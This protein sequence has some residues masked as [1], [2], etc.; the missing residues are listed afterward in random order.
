[1]KNTPDMIHGSIPKGILCFSLPLIA[2]NLLQVFYSAADTMIVSLSSEPDAVGAVGT[3]TPMITLVVNLFISC[4]I[5]AKVAAA[6]RLGAGDN[7]GTHRTV[8]TAVTLSIFLGILCCAAGQL[9]SAPA[10]RLMG[11]NGRLLE[12]SV[13]YT[14]I[15]FLGTPFVAVTNFAMAVFHARGDSKTPLAVLGCTGLLNVLLNMLLV[16]A[17]GLDV[18]GIAAAT[19]AANAVSAALLLW[20]LTKAD[21][22]VR[23]RL[24]RLGI[25]RAPLREILRIG[26]PAVAQNVLFNVSHILLQSSVV[27]VNNIVSSEGSAFQPVVKGNAVSVTFEEFGHTAVSSSAQAAISYTA[28]NIGARDYGRVDKIRRCGYL[29]SAAFALLFAAVMFLFKD[30]LLALYGVVPGAEGS[31]E[32]IAYETVSLRMLMVFLP[33]FLEGFMEVGSGIL[34]GLGRPMA[35]TVSSLLGSVLFRIVWILTV[36]RAHPT[37]PVVFLSYPLAWLLTSVPHYICGRIA[38]ARI[39]RADTPESA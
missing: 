24:S 4:S 38:L 35:S 12:L 27:T 9:I 18:E 34:Q 17:C 36:F 30:P 21:G 23:I 22:P 7:D 14:R 29:I 5:G 26:L 19:V 3:S 28:Q 8:R 6:Q 39:R 31:A 11:N 16:L 2:A 37:L 32:R 15:Y 33:Y 10:L 20:R 1:M 25:D 13:T